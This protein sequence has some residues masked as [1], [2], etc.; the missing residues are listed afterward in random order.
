MCQNEI[1]GS[2]F[3]TIIVYQLGKYLKLYKHKLLGKYYSAM[4]S[5]GLSL[6]LKMGCLCAKETVTV[7]GKKYIIREHLGEG[8]VIQLLFS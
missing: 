4:N 8:Y 3:F 1:R 6:I 7:N 5:L 2:L